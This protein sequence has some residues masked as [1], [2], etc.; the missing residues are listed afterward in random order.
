MFQ[1]KVGRV[2]HD[3]MVTQAYIWRRDPGR[4]IPP[5]LALGVRRFEPLS[6]HYLWDRGSVSA[7]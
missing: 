6:G 7:V 4:L 2:K 5:D 3:V 1:S